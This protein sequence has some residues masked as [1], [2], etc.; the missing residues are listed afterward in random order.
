VAVESVRAL[1]RAYAPE[2]ASVS[3]SAIDLRCDVAE[4]L[5]S[6]RVFGPY[7]TI[8]LAY[9]TA[10]LLT[11]DLRASGGPT[12]GGGGSAGVTVVPAVLAAGPVLLVLTLGLVVQESPERETMAVTTFLVLLEP[13]GGAAVAAAPA[14][15]GQTHLNLLA[16]T[17]V[18]EP[19]R[20]LP[21]HR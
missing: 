3:D 2:L 11:V 13:I 12:G 10:H 20:R 8:A 16:A 9:L 18:Q 6:A 15:P 14:R 17:A 7:Y 4:A 21:V 19:L 1:V 5:T